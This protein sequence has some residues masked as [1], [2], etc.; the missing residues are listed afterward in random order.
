MGRVKLPPDE[1]R[2]R[3]LESPDEAD[4]SKRYLKL[5]ENGAVQNWRADPVKHEHENSLQRERHAKKHQKT[6]KGPSPS[7]KRRR[8]DN[9]PSTSM[10]YEDV[11]SYPQPLW[12]KAKNSFLKAISDGPLH[13]CI[14]C[15]RELGR[16][17]IQCFQH[18]A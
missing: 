8:L 12:D 3:K 1:A 14:C 6:S 17:L 16:P 18:T 7:N 4:R 9:E 13:R 5:C 10:Y 15:E 2:R 11:P